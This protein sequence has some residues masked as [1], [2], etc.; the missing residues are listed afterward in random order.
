MRQPNRT[1]CFQSSI[2]KQNQC[3]SSL[4]LAPSWAQPP[5]KSRANS[6][7]SRK[8]LLECLRSTHPCP[9]FVSRLSSLA[10]LVSERSC[11]QS[12]VRS[13][14]GTRWL[15]GQLWMAPWW[16]RIISLGSYASWL[17]ASPCRRNFAPT[18][19]RQRITAPCSGS[20]VAFHAAHPHSSSYF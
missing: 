6:P 18:L 11:S 12:S 17:R 3:T 16:C 4:A 2:S 1:N 19:R 9:A 13:R 5:L 20:R 8:H 10:E 15:S 7:S 14:I